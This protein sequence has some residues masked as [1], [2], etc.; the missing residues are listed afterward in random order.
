MTPFTVPDACV[1]QTL[2]GPARRLRSDHETHR[3]DGFRADDGDGAS[4]RSPSRYRSSVAHAPESTAIV[5]TPF[6]RPRSRACAATSAP[7]TSAHRSSSTPSWRAVG[8]AEVGGHR[9]D[10]LGR[11][12]PGRP[13]SPGISARDRPAPR[14]AVVAPGGGGWL[15][16]PRPD[17]RR[18]RRRRVASIPSGTAPAVVS[19]RLARGQAG[20]EG[21]GAGAVELAEHVVEEEHRVV[22]GHLG[23]HAVAAQPQGQR[24]ACAAPP[25]RRGVRLSRPP[26]CRRHSSRCGPTSVTPR[27]SSWRAAGEERGAQQVVD[28]RRAPASPRPTRPRTGPPP[29][30]SSPASRGTPRRPR[31]R[32]APTSSSRPRTSSAPAATSCSSNTSRVDSASGPR[33][34]PFSSAFRCCSTRS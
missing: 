17:R 12:G 20:D 26:T 23:G 6:R 34:P 16:R 13:S 15:T 9:V 29:T 3:A 30:A 22:A 31:A 1:A 33:M 14:A 24:E 11:S 4:R 18:T 19:D 25:A 8:H 32:G 21:L 5:S 27:S 7:T 10:R 2:R 28:R